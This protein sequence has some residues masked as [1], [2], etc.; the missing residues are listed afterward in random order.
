MGEN[1]ALRFLTAFS[2]AT[3]VEYL[4]D[5]EKQN[6]LFFIDNIF[7][8]AQAGNELSV[9][10]NTIPSEDG[11]QSTLDSELAQFHE[12]LIS[13]T[14]SAVTSVE[15]IYVP[16]DDIIDY[17]VQAI[18]P[19][20]DSITVLSRSV[21]QE[22]L[23]PAIDIL[24][25]SSSALTPKIVGE[26]HYKVVVDTRQLLKQAVAMERIVALVGESELS[27]Q[28]QTAFHR[29]RKVRNYM[30]QRF[31]SAEEQRGQKGDYVPLATTIHDVRGIL[32]G[33]YDSMPEEKFLYI[34]SI[35][36]LDN[37]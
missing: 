28:D 13:A 21:Y 33:N 5:Q 31:F 26:D 25:S 24:A 35:K 30:T 17:G 3:L 23:L 8:F 20:F 10:M 7:R 16:A 12:R 6:I 19:Y 29:A 14:D 37:A 2:A 34:G 27:K 11:Y 32:D 9:L 22:G 36:D 4:R 1:P 15:A 18:F